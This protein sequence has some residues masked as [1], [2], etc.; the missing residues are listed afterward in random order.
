LF[1]PGVGS[2]NAWIYR[3]GERL[4]QG[5]GTDT[6][7]FNPSTEAEERYFFGGDPPFSPSTGTS[8]TRIDEFRMWSGTAGAGALLTQQNIIDGYLKNT[9]TANA[10]VLQAY[11][12]F[13]EQR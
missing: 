2:A 11:F 6:W 13:N 3:N 7:S 1:K 4:A 9:W 5:P 10:A 12:P 8:M